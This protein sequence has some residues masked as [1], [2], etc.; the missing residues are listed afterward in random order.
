MTASSVFEEKQGLLY[1]QLQFL[2]SDEV[3]TLSERITSDKLQVTKLNK[4]T[5]NLIDEG[6]NFSWAG[7][8]KVTGTIGLF[9]L[10]YEGQ[11]NFND[12]TG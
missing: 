4:V 5:K 11:I 12:E 9:G 3:N 7:Q 2:S 1:E 8:W 10:S 6:K